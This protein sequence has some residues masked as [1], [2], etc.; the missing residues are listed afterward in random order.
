MLTPFLQVRRYTHRVIS[1]QIK[2][3]NT[4]SLNCYFTTRSMPSTLQPEVQPL[5]FT[6]RDAR[7]KEKHTKKILTIQ[8]ICEVQ[9]PLL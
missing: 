4:R 8:N 1:Q 2:Q 9:P 3:L 6:L 7:G 5:S